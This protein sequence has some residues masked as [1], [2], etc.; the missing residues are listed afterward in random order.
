MAAQVSSMLTQTLGPG[1]AQV[2]VNADLNA[3]QATADQLKYTGKGIPLTQQTQTESLTGGGTTG[4]SAGTTGNIPA[5]AQAGAGGA[6]SKYKNKTANTTFGVD[7]TVTHSVIAPGNVNRQSVSVLI[8]KSVP[9]SEIP[10]LRAAVTNAVG[11]NTKR[12]DTLSFGQV[13]FAKPPTATTST[14]I[15]IIGYAKYALAGIAA[16]IFLFFM[17]RALK[18]REQES[19]AGQPTWVR[20]LSSPRPLAALETPAQPTQVM[21]LE[22]PVNVAK[23]QIEDLV[24][25][26]PDR[27]AQQVRAWMQED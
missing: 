27:V 25:R 7:K 20:E 9:A 15:N 26:D 5:Y 6:G 14:P 10:S 19:F 8:D 24:Q 22:P 23:R 3:N 4:A 16:I 2:Q 21:R 11:L 13:Q 1:K 17:R 18:K 12:G